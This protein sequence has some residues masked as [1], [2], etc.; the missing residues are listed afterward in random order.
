M[1]FETEDLEE[2]IDQAQAAAQDESLNVTFNEIEAENGARSYILEASGQR[3]ETMNEVLFEG[4]A[5]ISME[6]VD[7]QQRITITYDTSDSP[8]TE[9]GAPSAME[10]EMAQGMLDSFGLGF[11]F[12]IS[13]GEIISHNADR[14]WET[15][16]QI[17]VTL[18][19]A[20]ALDPETIT[21]VQPPAG[22]GGFSV[23]A[24]ESMMEAFEEGMGEMA[25][26][27]FES[28][29]AAPEAEAAP[30][31]EEAAPTTDTTEQAPAEEEMVVAESAEAEGAIVPAGE[32]QALPQ[33]G[34]ILPDESPIGPVVLAG[35]VLAAL[36]VGAATGL[37]RERR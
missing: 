5:D 9:E 8:A 35:L 16:S 25:E 24:M 21:F 30:A 23:E 37:G 26:G 28:E 7:G 12:R 34:A 36:G 14:V 31:E 1:S 10:E 22:E 32:E 17:Q 6:E 19:P 33:S 4:E 20:D 15:P 2:W 3:L 29:S 11:T 13:G 18:T 27:G